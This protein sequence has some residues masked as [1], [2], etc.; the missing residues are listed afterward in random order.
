MHLTPSIATI[1]VLVFVPWLLLALQ[2]NTMEV[3]A[4]PFLTR[5]SIEALAQDF[6][7]PNQTAVT[8]RCSAE[9]R[10]EDLHLVWQLEHRGLACMTMTL[11]TVT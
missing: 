5:Q 9:A 2:R 3:L 7:Q 4:R 6:L 8:V 10:G 11:A 1:Y